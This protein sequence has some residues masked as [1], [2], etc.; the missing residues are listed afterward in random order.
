MAKGDDTKSQDSRVEA[1]EFANVAT[2]Y[3]V[4]NL[5]LQCV[6]GEGE[7]L[8]RVMENGGG[9]NAEGGELCRAAFD[10][11][12]DRIEVGERLYE[13]RENSPPLTTPQVPQA[14]GRVEA[15]TRGFLTG[16]HA[17]SENYYASYMFGRTN[18]L[19]D[20]IDIPSNVALN[21]AVRSACVSNR[22]SGVA[23][24]RQYYDLAEGNSTPIE[25]CAAIGY[26]DGREDGGFAPPATPG[27]ATPQRSNGRN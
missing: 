18:S 11:L 8:A 23:L 6:R 15:T 1:E 21:E 14:A 5:A 19:P 25:N 12:N 16:R 24:D 3:S 26:A 13:G 4:Q 7:R 27:N 20:F 17:G 10:E 2:N 9:I 22:V